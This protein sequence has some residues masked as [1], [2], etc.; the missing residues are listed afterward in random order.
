MKNLIFLLLIIA[1]SAC[2]ENP[3]Q[4]DPGIMNAEMGNWNGLPELVF[5][6]LINANGTYKVIDQGGRPFYLLD[7]EASCPS[8]EE[9]ESYALVEVADLGSLQGIY[10]NNQEVDF[11]VIDGTINAVYDITYGLSHEEVCITYPELIQLPCLPAGSK[12]CAA[13]RMDCFENGSLISSGIIEVGPC[14]PCE[15]NGEDDQK[16]FNPLC[17]M[18]IIRE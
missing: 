14:S 17:Y 10:S 11:Y 1:V 13:V 9:A 15:F 8:E 4:P 2:G 3:V 7:G 12:K 5:D 16:P 6:E 18:E